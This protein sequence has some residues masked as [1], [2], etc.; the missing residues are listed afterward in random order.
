MQ[1][2]MRY[3]AIVRETIGQ[4]SEQRQ[5]AEE[6]IRDVDASRYWLGK[7]VTKVSEAGR[8]WEVEAEL[9]DYLQRYPVGCKPPFPQTAAP[10]S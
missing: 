8:F 1:I 5:V 2:E 6:T 7:T 4:A 3:F 10:L 9:Q